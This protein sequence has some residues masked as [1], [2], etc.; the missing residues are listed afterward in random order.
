MNS[1][2]PLSAVLLAVWSAIFM[3][4]IGVFSRLANL[5]AEHITFYRLLIGASSLLLFMLMSG[6]ATQII[7]A[8]SKRTVINGVMLAGFMV[9]YVQAISYISMAN[10][11]M[12][13]YLAPLVSALF[14]HFAF[15]ERLSRHN[16]ALIILALVG[17]ALMLPHTEAELPAQQQLGFAFAALAMLTYSGFMLMNRK[18]S[19]STPY[20]ST[21]VQLGVGALCLLPFVLITPII[22][23][24]SQWGWLFAIGLIPGFLAILFAVKALRALPAVT[25]GTLAYIEPVAVVIFAWTLFEESLSGIQLLGA[26]LII[27][28][29]ICQGILVKSSQGDKA[30]AIQ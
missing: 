22:P 17:F 7:H 14:A 23:T 13:I 10:A 12:L 4:T 18:P 24:T 20:Q 26:S 2:P 5:P 27:T 6:K 8:P 1:T 30:I 19:Q 3:A 9:F 11:V 21:L 25:F 28:A 15:K 16:V 29:G